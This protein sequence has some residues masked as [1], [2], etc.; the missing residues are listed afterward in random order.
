MNLR[1]RTQKPI[2]TLPMLNG[3]VYAVWDPIAVPAGP[4]N[5]HL[6]TIPQSADGEKLVHEV[7]AGVPISFV[8]PGIKSMSEAAVANG[9]VS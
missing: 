6:S 3:K 9:L 7:V 8:G 5:K 2:A 4:R 1:R